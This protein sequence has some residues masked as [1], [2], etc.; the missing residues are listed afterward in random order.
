MYLD[1]VWPNV[2]PA[3]AL[4]V[5]DLEESGGEGVVV[6]PPAG[7]E[8]GCHDG[9]L[10]DHVDAGEVVHGL[11]DLPTVDVGSVEVRLETSVELSVCLLLLAGH[12]PDA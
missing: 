4:M 7:P 6:D 9:G 8:G 11:P 12:Q 5:N 2:C 10:W 1:H 3:V